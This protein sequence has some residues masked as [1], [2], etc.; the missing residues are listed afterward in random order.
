MVV[1][2]SQED[3]FAGAAAPL[4]PPLRTLSLPCKGCGATERRNAVVRLELPSLSNLRGELVSV[5]P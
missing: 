2:R 1:P 4:V 3:V 5:S